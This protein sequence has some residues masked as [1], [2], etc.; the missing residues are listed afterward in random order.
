MKLKIIVQLGVSVL[1]PFI[2]FFETGVATQI[3]AAVSSAA[4]SQQIRC[5]F[6]SV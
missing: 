2:G 1:D 4:N 5:H 3:A 6:A